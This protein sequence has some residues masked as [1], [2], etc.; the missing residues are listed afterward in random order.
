MAE[1]GDLQGFGEVSR[2][3]IE[4]GVRSHPR[5]LRKMAV[6]AARGGAWE[7]CES[8]VQMLQNQD[9]APP[10]RFLMRRLDGIR[11]QE[12]QKPAPSEEVKSPHS[13]NK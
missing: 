1:A 7:V 5:A 3:M 10:P 2:H 13:S 6:S 4:R 12:K 9:G 11:A 8:A